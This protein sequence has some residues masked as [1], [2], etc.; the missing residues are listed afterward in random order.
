MISLR[1]VEVLHAVL[2][3]GSITKAAQWLN[4]TQPAVSI[5]VRQLEQRLRFALFERSHGR[6]KPTAEARA[7]MPD[8]EG[9]FRHLRAMER[10]SED[11]ATGTGA[12]FSVAATPPLC[13]G[14]VANA[15]ARFA[16]HRPDAGIQV[17]AIASAA[18]VDRVISGEADLGVVYEPVVSAA[19]KVEEIGRAHIACLLPRGHRLARRRAVTAADLSGERVITYLPQA[20]LRPYIDRVLAGSEQPPSPRL[21]TGASSTAIALA[22]EGAGIALVESALFMARPYRNLVMRPLVPQVEMKV[23]LLRARPAS[24]SRA[25]GEFIEQLRASFKASAGRP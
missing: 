25:V 6:L 13:D 5:A 3:T 19:V 16:A 22:A 8:L 9:M 10:L 14:F 20:L 4:V 17:Q 12:A 7:L 2:R 1:Q 11:L 18:V 15:V 23:L 24:Q 21:L